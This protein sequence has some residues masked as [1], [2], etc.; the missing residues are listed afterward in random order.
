MVSVRSARSRRP[1]NACGSL[2]GQP[3]T[4]AAALLVDDAVLVVVRLV[5]GEEQD[6]DECGKSDGVGHDVGQ[7]RA[8]CEARHEL[9]HRKED[10]AHAGEHDEVGHRRPNG[11]ELDVSHALVREGVFLLD[12]HYASPP[13]ESEAPRCVASAR[14]CGLTYADAL[15]SCEYADPS[16]SEPSDALTVTGAAVLPLV[17][18]VILHAT[19]CS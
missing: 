1:K 14:R 19:A 4:L 2:R 13:S 15:R 9:A 8:L 11:A 16:H 17:S 7:R 12:R 18:D 6:E 3:D 5:F 10:D